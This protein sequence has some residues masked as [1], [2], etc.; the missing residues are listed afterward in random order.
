VRIIVFAKKGFED[1]LIEAV[2]NW[3]ASNCILT[4]LDTLYLEI[5]VN[6]SQD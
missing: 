6:Q 2:T 3:T 1:Q 4:E 5:P